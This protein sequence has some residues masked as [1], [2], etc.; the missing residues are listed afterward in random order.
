MAELNSVKKSEWPEKFKSFESAFLGFKKQ[1]MESKPQVGNIIEHGELK[2]FLQTL[3]GY[4]NI[5]D[6]CLKAS[7]S[8]SN[9][10][11]LLQSQKLMALLGTEINTQLRE[12]GFN[13]K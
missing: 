9:D 5:I 12:Q 1:R 4:G 2:G 7:L 6:A 13:V 10:K 3:V 11:S 8:D